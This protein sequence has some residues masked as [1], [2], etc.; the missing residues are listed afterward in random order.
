MSILETI[1]SVLDVAKGVDVK[2]IIGAS[3]DVY[4]KFAALVGSIALLVKTV[5]YFSKN[6]IAQRILAFLGKLVSKA[7]HPNQ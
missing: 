5:P 6:S 1:T 2:S 4:A 3:L 7:P